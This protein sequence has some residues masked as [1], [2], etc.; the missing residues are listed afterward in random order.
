ML[1]DWDKRFPG[2]IETMFQAMQNIVPSHLT[3]KNLFDFAGLSKESALPVEGD[4]A[5]D[6]V[7]VPTVPVG[8]ESDEDEPV[9][10][11]AVELV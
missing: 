5:F 3:D 6:K 10:T 4:T 9:L 8:L 7:A 11:Q 1:Q 2:R